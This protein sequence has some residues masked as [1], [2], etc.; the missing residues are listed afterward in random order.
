MYISTEEC[1]LVCVYAHTLLSTPVHTYKHTVKTD[2]HVHRQT[3]RDSFLSSFFLV[4]TYFR[5]AISE[6][7]K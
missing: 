4:P 1:V 5:V 3:G 2:T 6:L 7:Y